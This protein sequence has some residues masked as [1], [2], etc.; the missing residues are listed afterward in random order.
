MQVKAEYLP[1]WLVMLG[2]AVV[3]AL[4]SGLIVVGGSHPVEPAVLAILLGILLANVHILPESTRA[5]ITVFETPLIWGIV[6]IGAGL[7][8]SN[9]MGQG[10]QMLSVIIITMFIG[11]WAIYF[12]GKAF[13]LTQRLSLLLSV[14]TTICGGSA[15]AVTAPLIDA[16]EEETS[17][18]IGTI[19]LWGVVAM[20]AYP[21][22]FRVIAPHADTIFGLF[23][24]V[25]V[26]STPQ[27]V[28]AG[29]IF[30]EL[31][32]DIATAT[33]LVRNTF[34][35]PLA[36]VIA[37][38]YGSC[39]R[40]REEACEEGETPKTVNWMKGFPWFLFG[41]F[42]MV[43]LRSYGFFTETAIAS[44]TSWGKFL[45]LVGMAGIGLNT[46][47]SAFKGIGG[48]PLVVGVIGAMILAVA[49]LVLIRAL[50]V[51]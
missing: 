44:F 46:R 2:I 38:W 50:G 27:A 22:L 7:D 20:M 49:S 5:G 36:L 41:Y 47:F 15:I 8:I 17:Y 9:I 23:A 14:G 34:I 25:A 48:K 51:A 26:Q 3:S 11:F 31:A 24:G 45:I 39:V 37:V 13:G 32:G 21:W 42:V 16:K 40:G 4:V 35:A 30:S 6:L 1:G 28:G 43:A 19:A 29:F 12:L 33:K 10:W 18:A